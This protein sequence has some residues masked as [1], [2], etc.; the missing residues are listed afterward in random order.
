M[1][2]HLS[3]VPNSCG[4]A[5]IKKLSHINCIS[6]HCYLSKAEVIQLALKNSTSQG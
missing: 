5:L 1:T 3:C 4:Y 6:L 2:G